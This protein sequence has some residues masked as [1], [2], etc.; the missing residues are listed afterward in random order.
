[1]LYFSITLKLNPIRP[2]GGGGGGGGCW[3]RMAESARAEFERY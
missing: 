1:M 2:G 3:G